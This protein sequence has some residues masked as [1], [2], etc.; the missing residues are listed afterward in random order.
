MTAIKDQSDKSRVEDMLKLMK[1][2]EAKI[3][4]ATAEIKEYKDEFMEIAE[5]HPEWFEQ[6]K[7]VQFDNG[8]LRYVNKSELKKTGKFDLKKF[9]KSFPNLV[10]ISTTL[11]LKNILVYMEDKAQKKE[12]NE[13]GL[14]V[15]QTLKFEAKTNG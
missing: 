9:V 8:Q 10:K 12:M 11:T 1:K 6:T 3:K 14:Q 13:L 7:T 15:V 5:R 4:N 2:Q